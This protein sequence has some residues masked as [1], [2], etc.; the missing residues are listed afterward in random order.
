MQTNQYQKDSFGKMMSHLYHQGI[1][2]TYQQYIDA[3]MQMEQWEDIIQL[4]YKTSKIKGWK[5]LD[6]SLLYALL[7]KLAQQLPLCARDEKNLKE[8][9]H[10]LEES[11]QLDNEHFLRR[12]YV[13]QKILDY[14]KFMHI[15]KIE[16]INERFACDV[17]L[18]FQAY[19]KEAYQILRKWQYHDVLF[20]EQFSYHFI[21]YFY[22]L[23]PKYQEE[24]QC[25]VYDLY[26]MH[27]DEEKAHRAYQQLLKN[28]D[29][30]G[31]IAYRYA[32]IYQQYQQ[33]KVEDLIIKLV[34]DKQINDEDKEQLLAL[35]S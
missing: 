35:L 21:A 24:L 9:L 5:K 27:H 19:Q 34:R 13:L 11:T 6:H 29:N 14:A 22:E 26:M 31:K 28:S 8:D 2:F 32:S 33:A 18:L 20:H 25:D 3:L 4:V 12:Y 1:R 15:N 16:T 23:Y 30:K 17:E 10:L 7:E